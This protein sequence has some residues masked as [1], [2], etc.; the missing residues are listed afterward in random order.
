[1]AYKDNEKRKAWERAYRLTNAD[2]LKAY[3]KPYLKAYEK[4]RK[5]RDR[6]DYQKAY[7]KAYRETHKV[8]R[9]SRP[10]YTEEYRLAKLNR[11]KACKRAYCLANKDKEAVRSRKRRALKLGNNHEP[12]TDKYIF[13]RD[14]WI[15]G[16][17][18]QKINKRLKYPNPRS[19]SIDHIVPLS[20]GGADAPINL[21]AAH[22][23][24]NVG[25]SAKSGGQL[26]LIG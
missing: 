14:G 1:M 17:C 2:R 23:R 12:Y 18:G 3:M 4:T 10:I 6:K 24:C 8:E 20:K 11:I 25:K 13:E 15:C 16:I 26:R 22:L 19:K 5:P 7:Q 9:A 21:Q